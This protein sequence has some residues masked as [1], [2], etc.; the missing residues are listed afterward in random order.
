MYEIHVVIGLLL[1]QVLMQLR[2]ETNLDSDIRVV[3]EARLQGNM[4]FSIF[5]L[6]NTMFQDSKAIFSSDFNSA[7]PHVGQNLES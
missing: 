1:W 4:H 5:H 7:L 3:E 6:R 2:V